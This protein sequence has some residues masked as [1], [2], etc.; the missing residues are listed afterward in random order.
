[1]IYFIKMTCIYNSNLF[2]PVIPL[3]IFSSSFTYRENL[4]GRCIN[5]SLLR[6][7]NMGGNNL[8]KY[9]KEETLWIVF[10][11]KISRSHRLYE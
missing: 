5:V 1:M 7:V 9:L 6:L 2:T 8:F 3:V 4:V 11:K 10:C